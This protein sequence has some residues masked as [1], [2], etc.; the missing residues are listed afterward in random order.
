MRYLL[1]PILWFLGISG[2]LVLPASA[3]AL[4]GHLIQN[5]LRDIPAWVR[6]DFTSRNLDNEYKIIYRLYP[7]VISGDFNGDGRKDVAIQIQSLSSGKTGIAIFH[8]RKPQA[9]VTNIAILGAGKTVGQA[10]D[11]LSWSE[12][13]VKLKGQ[14]MNAGDLHSKRTPDAISLSNKTDRTVVLYWNGRQ[15]TTRQPRR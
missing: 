10:G 4:Q 14:G 3:S 13:W 1:T 7:H 5:P 15:Y 2:T 12:V 6:R 8:G 11:N 9:M